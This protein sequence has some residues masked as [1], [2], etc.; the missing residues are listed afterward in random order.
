MNCEQWPCV[1][2]CTHTNL[3]QDER[4]PLIPPSDSPTPPRRMQPPKRSTTVSPV[5]SRVTIVEEVFEEVTHN[6][7]GAAVVPT[8]TTAESDRES[9]ELLKPDG[10][11]NT[12][13]MPRILLFS[14]YG[15]AG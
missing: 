8:V 14:M 6:T 9:K 4:R 12:I 1:N 7:V 11:Q 3:S 15:M 5:P 2:L 10:G 13:P